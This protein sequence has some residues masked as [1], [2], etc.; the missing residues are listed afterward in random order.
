MECQL[1]P[2]LANTMAAKKLP[3]GMSLLA[4]CLK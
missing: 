4:G 1:R 3:G 2:F